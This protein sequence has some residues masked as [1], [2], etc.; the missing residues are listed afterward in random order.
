M[1]CSHFFAELFSQICV[2]KIQILTTASVL[3]PESV[4]AEL[5]KVALAPIALVGESHQYPPVN[6]ASI[7]SPLMRLD[8]GKS[9]SFLLKLL[10]SSQE[11]FF[12][13]TFTNFGALFRT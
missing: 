12:N 4:P 5:V 3:G 8:F 10:Y 9:R 1:Q 2:Y 11:F 6:W 7:L 13:A